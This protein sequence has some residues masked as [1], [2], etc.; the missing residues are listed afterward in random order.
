[1]VATGGAVA[2]HLCS[3]SENLGKIAGLMVENTFTSIPHVAR[4]MLNVRLVQH[5]PN[6]CYKNKRTFKISSIAFPWMD[7]NLSQIVTPL[8]LRD[9]ETVNFMAKFER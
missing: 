1:M 8:S 7:N 4:S 2:I 9:Y 6:F 5:L 3:Q